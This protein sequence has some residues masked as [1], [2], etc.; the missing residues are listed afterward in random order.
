MVLY[1]VPVALQAS[2]RD[3]C[4]P[5]LS[6]T[7]TNISKNC[8]ALLISPLLMEGGRVEERGREGGGGEREGG[9]MEER[10]R[11]ERGR[12]GGVISFFLVRRLVCKPFK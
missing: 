9:R 8:A 2:A 1:M 3:S 6:A 12:E 7:L 11:E 10:G 5:A 4:K